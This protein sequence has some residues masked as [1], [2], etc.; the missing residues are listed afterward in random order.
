MSRI[1]NRSGRAILAIG[2]IALLPPSGS[3]AERTYSPTPIV[4]VRC[5]P[6]VLYRDG[7]LVVELAGSPHNDFDFGVRPSSVQSKNPDDLFLLSFK[8]GKNDRTAPVVPPQKFAAMKQITLNPATARGSLSNWWRGD[9]VPRALRP[10]E[11]I[12]T[13]SGLYQILL[14]RG[15]G[16]EDPSVDACD[17]D[18]VNEA[19]V[20][21]AALPDPALYTVG[22]S[23]ETGPCNARTFETAVT[24]PATTIHRGDRLTLELK[25]KY[26][27]RRIGIVDPDWNAFLLPATQDPAH[28]FPGVRIVAG[29]EIARADAWE[30]IPSYGIRSVHVETKGGPVFTKSGWYIAIAL[31][32][33]QCDIETDVGACWIHYI[34]TPAFSTNEGA[35]GRGR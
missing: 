33:P 3:G 11:L 15:L 26:P 13:D 16:S 4:E 28:S 5:H 12:F 27:A 23:F 6:P 18:Y 30:S 29:S 17:V 34:D 20:A 35:G 25:S 14:G 7:V 1:R 31:P 10:P 9:E 2:V 21:G 19:K 24:C 32:G 22:R 8:P